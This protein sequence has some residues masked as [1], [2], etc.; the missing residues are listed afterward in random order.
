M[1]KVGHGVTVDGRDTFKMA[2]KLRTNDA[3]LRFLAALNFD[4]E[5]GVEAVDAA[6]EKA[7]IFDTEDNAPPP[8]P[9]RRWT[10]R[11][12]SGPTSPPR[13]RR[14]RPSAQLGRRNRLAVRPNR[15]SPGRIFRPPSDLAMLRTLRHRSSPSC[16]RTTN[17]KIGA[18]IAP[19]RGPASPATA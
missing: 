4:G 14:N 7:V 18:D 11:R 16:C 2:E 15:A 3:T 6:I 13:A 1:R 12:S 5:P 10:L 8:P 9:P 19:R 17:R